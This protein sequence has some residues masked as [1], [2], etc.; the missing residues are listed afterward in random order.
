MI[1]LHQGLFRSIQTA[2][3]E[4]RLH[5]FQ[6]H[7]VFLLPRYKLLSLRRQLPPKSSVFAKLNEEE[8]EAHGVYEVGRGN[9]ALKLK[10]EQI[11]INFDSCTPGQ[12][13]LLICPLCKGGQSKGRTLS[14]HK[15]Q[16]EKVA[17]WRCFNFECGLSGHVLADVSPIQEEVNKVNVPKKPSEETLR[18]EP[19]GDE[20]IEYFATRKISEEILKKNAVMQM[21]DD[22]NVIAYT[23][24]R[25]GELVNCKF[26]SITSRKFWQAKHGER[27]LYGLDGI[28][29]GHD[30][31]IVI[32]EGEIDKLSM[33]EAG[34][35]NC[36]S[37]PDGAPQ[38][39]SIKASPSKK[40]EARF[41]YLSDCNGCLD[42]ASRIILATD[43]DG[44]GQALAEELSCR[45]G[46][47]RCWVVT[48]PKKDE[49]S[50]YKDANEV[51][52]HLGA[53]AL[54]HIVENAK[55]YEEQKI[56]AVL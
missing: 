42:K 31:V 12:Y 29:E 54:R 21:I 23:Y 34:I 8:K 47:Q 41:K 35:I 56:Y 24:R 37:V 43:G 32:V 14:F 48:W 11:G 50:H 10:V 13:T 40:Q 1:S 53:E 22:K 39:V 55:L 17:M 4:P 7:L 26:R 5:R 33:E 2:I 28:K 3:Y 25:N 16:N 27:I 15:N 6:A 46:K 19:L 36:V 9:K 45:L 44:P 38:H 20:L 51:L 30:I 52:V 18:L 49:V